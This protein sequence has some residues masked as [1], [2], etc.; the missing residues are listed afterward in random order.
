MLQPPMV[1]KSRQWRVCWRIRLY[2]WV[3]KLPQFCKPT[4]VRWIKAPTYPF[5]KFGKYRWLPGAG[6]FGRDFHP[7]EWDEE[8]RTYLTQKMKGGKP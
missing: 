4:V 7:S 2:S 6:T 5:G 1:Q 8:L 3:D